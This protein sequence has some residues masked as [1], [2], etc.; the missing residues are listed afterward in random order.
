MH[1]QVLLNMSPSNQD[2]IPASTT[3]N[4][5]SRQN[6]ERTSVNGVNTNDQGE[7][8]GGNV[9]GEQDATRLA[10]YLETVTPTQDQVQAWDISSGSSS[11]PAS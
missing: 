1:L 8:G 3:S 5:L 7:T 2:S 9:T 6:T 11:T 10:V 4:S